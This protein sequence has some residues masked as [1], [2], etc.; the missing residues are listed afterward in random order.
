[1]TARLATSTM[2]SLNHSNGFYPTQK[3]DGYPDNP[4]PT[5]QVIEDEATVYTFELD[6][7]KV[8]GTNNDMAL[9]GAHFDLYKYIGE[10]SDKVTEANLK[11]T[12]KAKKIRDDLVSDVDGK[13]VKEND[14]TPLYFGN[15][16]YYL[17]ETKAPDGYNLLKDPVKVRNRMWPILPLR[18]KP[19][20]SRQ[21]RMGR[22]LLR[23]LKLPTPHTTM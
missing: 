11:D 4:N 7:K 8:D 23:K 5:E 2:R 18:R 6:I 19:L 21:M 13:L 20:P 1:M 17:V 10:P 3:P 14:D 22:L 15:G 12:T 16:N 9:A